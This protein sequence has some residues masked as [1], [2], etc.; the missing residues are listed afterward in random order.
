MLESQ[1]NIFCNLRKEE[2]EGLRELRNNEQIKP[3]DKG[4]AVVVMETTDCI[5]ECTR[6]LDNTTYYRI[7]TS[8][9]TNSFN[10]KNQEAIDKGIEEKEISSEIGKAL[11][12][13]HPTPGRFYI[14]LKIYKEGNPGRPIIGGDGCPAEIISQFVD[15]HMKDLVS[16]LPSYVQDDMDFLRKIHDINKTGPLPPDTLLCTMDVSALYSNISHK[17]DRRREAIP[18][19]IMAAFRRPKNLRDS[20]VHSSASRRDTVG[21]RP[22]NIPRCMTCTSITSSTTFTSTITRKSYNILHNLTQRHLSHYM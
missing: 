2:K 20:L 16:Q 14:L 9:P 18:I 8:D 5:G 22:C 15:Y 1:R 21:S 12:V 13:P 10:K 19:L 7:F 17:E 4:G 6:Q 11:L 3:A